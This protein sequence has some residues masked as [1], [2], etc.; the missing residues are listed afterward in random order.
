MPYAWLTFAEARAE[1][2]ARLADSTQQRWTDAEA[3]L[4]IQEALRM[5]N[6]MTNTWIA[7]CVLGTAGGWQNL[8]A[9]PCARMRTCTDVQQ[10]TL[11]E[12]HLQ[13]PPTGGVWTGT[14][15]FTIAD[16]SM[17]LM[18]R[19]NEV[20]S[21]ADCNLALGTVPS[22]PNRRRQPLPDSTL[23]LMRVR[24]LPVAPPSELRP[25]ITLV[26][27]DRLAFEYFAPGFYQQEPAL[28]LAW[29]IAAEPPL[30]FDVDVPPSVEGVY[31][32]ISLVA[33]D[34]F[35]PPAVT[36]LGIPDDFAWVL[37]W[38]ALA[39]L[40]GRESEATDR[41]RAA[42]CQKRYEDGLKLLTATPWI[43]LASLDGQAADVCAMT[44]MDRYAPEWDSDP[45]FTDSVVFAGID[46]L[47]S[48]P[49]YALGLTLLGNAP[50]PVLDT[51][52][53]QVA[54][55]DWDAV[56]SMAQLLA[57]FNVGGAEFEQA[58][59][60]ETVF[61]KAAAQE[62]IRL[63]KLGIFSDILN[64]RAGAEARRQERSDE[65]S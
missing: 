21:A 43:R 11:M 20:Q 47:W 12:Y 8:G 53:V 39:D 10:Y 2:A 57:T 34:T 1:L 31:E 16:L 50:V 40:L 19:R 33:G 45:R 36:L 58:L 30:S 26:R 62:N 22:A 14:S 41:A 63:E 7:D 5:W 56:L 61:V 23:E 59:S 37:R 4:Y 9:L 6:S 17:A 24:F 3:G 28:P 38:G 35:A 27:D 46:F 54:R 29:M 55:G 44:D 18:R 15:Q 65:Q 60:L 25:P 52:Y 64:Q 32:T 51:D 42:W 49:G 13:E 48:P